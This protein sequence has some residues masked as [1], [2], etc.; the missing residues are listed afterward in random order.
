M[1]SLVIYRLIYLVC[2]FGFW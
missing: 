2:Y 1:V